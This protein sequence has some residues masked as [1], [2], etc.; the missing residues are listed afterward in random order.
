MAVKKWATTNGTVWSFNGSIVTSLVDS[1]NPQ[2]IPPSTIRLKF[3]DPNYNPSTHTFYVTGSSST[4]ANISWRQVSSEPNVWDGYYPPY[5][6]GAYTSWQSMF[7]GEFNDH[8]NVVEVVGANLDGVYRATNLFA[9]CSSLLSVSSFD[10]GSAIECQG[11]FKNCT[12]LRTVGDIAIHGDDLYSGTTHVGFPSVYEMFEDCSSLTTVGNITLDHMTSLQDMF[13]RCQALTSMG[14]VYAPE[15]E[16]LQNTFY[17]CSSLANWPSITISPNA[18]NFV[19]TFY[20]CNALTSCPISSDLLNKATNCTTMFAYCRSLTAFPIFD[21]SQVT[22]MSQ[23]FQECVSIT[24][25]IPAYDLRNIDACNS[26]FSGCTNVSGGILDTYNRFM[27]YTIQPTSHSSTFKSCGTNS[28]TG[29]A[30]LAQIP[31]DWK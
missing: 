14:T 31:S 18:S 3:S 2:G 20:T 12:N 6:A 8:T 26:A 24:G 9:N 22:R 19:G 28:Q 17:L 25:S 27:S 13:Y 11:M 10:F 21:M 30:E 5:A 4:P 15:A 16:D 7:Q 1:E 29:S 23:M